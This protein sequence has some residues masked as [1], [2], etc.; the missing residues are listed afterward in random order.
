MMILVIHYD[1]NNRQEEV[2][3]T[4]DF[5]KKRKPYQSQRQIAGLYI[6]CQFA[7]PIVWCVTGIAELKDYP[8]N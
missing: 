4:Q 2:Y 1:F 3:H 5:I 7:A 8:I 6:L